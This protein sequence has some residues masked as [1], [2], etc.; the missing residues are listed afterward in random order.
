MSVKIISDLKRGE[1]LLDAIIAFANADHDDALVVHRTD[2]C[3]MRDAIEHYRKQGRKI[4]RLSAALS[5]LEESGIGNMIG[6]QGIVLT[7]PKLCIVT[8]AV[9]RT[10]AARVQGEKEETE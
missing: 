9:N 7:L 1:V 8:D 3:Y 4:E 6:V 10:I 5:T 2:A